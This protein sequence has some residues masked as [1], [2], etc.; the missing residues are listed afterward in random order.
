MKVVSTIAELRNAVGQ[1][2]AE[3]L[4][5]GLVP[6]MGAL[7][8]GHLS[9]VRTAAGQCQYVVVSIF[10]NP[11][12]FNN[13]EDL[14]TYP[15]NL[16]ADTALLSADGHASLVFAPSVSEVYPEPDTRQFDLGPLAEV[17]EGA[18]RPGHFNG[19]AQVVSKL[20]EF[21]APDR[22]YF[23]EKDFQQL[24]IIRKM[25]ADLGL[26]ID[27]VGC[28]IVRQ[29]NGLAISSR[30]T[31]LDD[32][33]RRNAPQIHAI[34]VLSTTEVGRMTPAELIADV[35]R[36]VNNTPTLRVEYFDI[37]DG[38]TLQS[39]NA[40]GDTDYVVGCITVYAGKV[41]LIDNITYKHRAS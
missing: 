3:H 39:I 19:V 35:T 13:P 30:N 11:T 40:W 7:H 12:Q 23:G 37:V 20:F 38:L 21:V 4:S 1:A 28:P 15:R 8:D 34:L 6:T 9:L 26:N 41:R 32:D 17:M 14:R 2:R 25:T 22:A 31:L 5:V 36:Q 27:V 29:A 10:V 16:E 24:A 18:Y 33:A